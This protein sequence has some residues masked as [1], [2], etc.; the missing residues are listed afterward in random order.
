M[1]INRLIKI[2]NGL[3]RNNK[4]SVVKIDQAQSIELNILVV[5]SIKTQFG[6]TIRA[7]LFDAGDHC[8]WDNIVSHYHQEDC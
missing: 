6:Y 5:Y 7:A 2:E 3:I 1:D 4:K 8:K